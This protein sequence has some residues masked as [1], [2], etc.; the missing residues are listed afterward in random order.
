LE[1]VRLQV[2][3]DEEQASF[4]RR[5]RTVL[6]HPKLAG[7]PRFPI[8]APRRHVGLK[9]GLERRDQLLKFVERQAGHIQKLCGAILHVG[10]LEIRHE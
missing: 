4:R 9:R 2:R 5:E 7:G 1:A 8:E 3:E 6:I 10:A